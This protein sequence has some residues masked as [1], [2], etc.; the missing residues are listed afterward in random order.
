MAIDKPP[1]SRPYAEAHIDRPFG[2][3]RVEIPVVLELWFHPVDPVKELFDETGVN[4]EPA[5]RVR[6]TPPHGQ[7]VPAIVEVLVVVRRIH[8]ALG[9]M[10]S[11]AVSSR[12]TG[13]RRVS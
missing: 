2:H 9:I 7:L 13:T 11:Y 8:L 6:Q 12:F 10:I 1:I 3:H 4:E 5:F